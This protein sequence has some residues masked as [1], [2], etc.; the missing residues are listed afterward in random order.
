ML[1]RCGNNYEG[2]NAH[3][4]LGTT[5]LETFAQNTEL[6]IR[7]HPLNVF[8]WIVSCDSFLTSQLAYKLF[9]G[10]DHVFYNID[11]MG[12]IVSP[13]NL[14]AEVL[15]VVLQN[16]TLFTEQVFTEVIK[17]EIRSLGLTLK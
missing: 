4:C 3:V 17:L 13:E 11:V 2:A 1:P 10:R 7:L 16:M 6:I 9:V 5:T 8:S 12:W 15:T 14:Y